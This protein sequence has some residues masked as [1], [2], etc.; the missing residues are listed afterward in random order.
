MALKDETVAR[1]IDTKGQICPYPII[2]TRGELKK[3]AVGAVLEVITDN[4]QTANET[5]PALLA[6]RAFP[7]EREEVSP[8]VWRFLIQRSS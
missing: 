7:Y 4:P 6:A 2:A 8:G 3:L 1:S 5:M